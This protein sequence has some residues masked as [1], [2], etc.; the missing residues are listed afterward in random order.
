MT[1]LK[2]ECGAEIPLNYSTLE[3]LDIQEELGSID[4]AINQLNGI[5][6][7]DL[8]DKS[9]IAGRDQLKA[10]G[11]FLRVLGNS[12]LKERGEETNLEDRKILSWIRPFEIYVA[13][14]AVMDEIAVGM[15]SEIP[16][17]KKEGPVDVVL[18]EIEKKKERDG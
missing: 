14:N 11:V 2:L 16:E 6:P 12:A 8:T 15:H 10:L 3:M 18:E 5:N 9:R 4:Q 17:K 13:V 7:D 1:I